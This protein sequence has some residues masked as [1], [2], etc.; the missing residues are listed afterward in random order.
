MTVENLDPKCYWLTNHLETLL[1]QIWYPSTV[2]TL[3]L[4]VK[5]IILSYLEQTGDPS[6]IDWKLHDFGYRGSTSVESAGLGGMAHLV[7]FKGTD[8]YRAIEYA[9]QYYN[10]AMAGGS[11]PAAEH[12]TIT[13][14]GKAKE[15]EAFRNML[16]KYP[17]GLVAVVSDSYDI[18]N[19][20]R[21]LWG[22]ELREEVLARDGTVVIR[23]DSGNPSEIVCEVLK[24]LWSKFGGTINEKGYRVLDDHV[25]VI[26]GDG[27]G[28]YN[29]TPDPG[30]PTRR[31]TTE[32]ILEA[33]KKEGYSADNITFGSGGGLLQKMDRDTQKFAFK[34]SAIKW[35]GVWA[36]VYK[37]PRTDPSKDSPKG[38]LQLF[39]RRHL[40]PGQQLPEEFGQTCV[41]RR[42]GQI[43]DAPDQL[44]TVFEYGDI[45]K[46]HDFEEI[47]ARAASGLSLEP[48][49]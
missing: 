16:K 44:L 39:L 4:E 22:K 11:I 49:H 10:A 38:R 34:C 29:P 40:P 31:H 19:A 28:W 5:K 26:Q 35:N 45:T 36:D 12:S 43:K 24:I 30:D 18:L 1:C 13:A 14:W 27:I 48:I 9:A 32:D 2:A 37:K 6:L 33:M 21:E 8:T 41:T 47:R 3:S 15:A 42:L 46:L 23:P 7:N 17:K 25:R 20:C